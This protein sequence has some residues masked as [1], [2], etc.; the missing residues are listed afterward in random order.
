MAYLNI[1]KREKKCIK[2]IKREVKVCF[3]PCNINKQWR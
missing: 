3:Y 2:L 1:I